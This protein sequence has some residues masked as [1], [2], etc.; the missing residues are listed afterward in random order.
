[1]PSLPT[2][3][4]I[5][6]ISL[7]NLVS[8]RGLY[9]FFHFHCFFDL[10]DHE[11]SIGGRGPRTSQNA[12]P[13]LFTQDI[14]DRV[15]SGRAPERPVLGPLTLG[16]KFENGSRGDPKW[17]RIIIILNFALSELSLYISLRMH[18]GVRFSSLHHVSPSPAACHGTRSERNPNSPD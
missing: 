1:M 13:R 4:P 10:S 17:T 2:S 8:S 14:L 6:A 5:R 16:G 9:S 11:H 12:S 3:L 18:L 15:G 7:R